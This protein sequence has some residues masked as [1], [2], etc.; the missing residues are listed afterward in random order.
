MR[1]QKWP[2]NEIFQLVYSLVPPTSPGWH[3]ETV[4]LGGAT[5]REVESGPITEV[6]TRTPA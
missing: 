6:S 3:L 4:V 2:Y 1:S 5:Q